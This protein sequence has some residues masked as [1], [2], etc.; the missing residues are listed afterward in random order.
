M[1]PKEKA[2]EL[3]NYYGTLFGRYDKS[4]IAAVKCVDEI[5]QF[6]KNDDD[7]TDSCFWANHKNS[8]FWDDVRTELG[9]LS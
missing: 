3:W 6:M 1:T 7:E 5:Y 4:S 2:W 9:K 8:K